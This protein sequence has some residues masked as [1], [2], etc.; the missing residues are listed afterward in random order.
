MGMLRGV[1][2]TF[3][4]RLSARAYASRTRSYAEAWC[5]NG[6]TPFLAL[7]REIT[8]KSPLVKERAFAWARRRGRELFVFEELAGAGVDEDGVARV[9][10]S[11]HHVPDGDLEFVTVTDG[12]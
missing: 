12:E 5:G 7:L 1:A 3:S 11:P 2:G 8:Y 10:G 6:S 4:L 9:F